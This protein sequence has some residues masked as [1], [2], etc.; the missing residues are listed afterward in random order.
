VAAEPDDQRD[1]GAN[2]L[3]FD[4]KNPDV[5]TRRLHQRRRAVG[6]LI[7]G[8]PEGGIYKTT[9]AGRSWTKLTRP[10]RG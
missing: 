3:A 7:G 1:T 4:P 9:N 2:D 6:Q 5:R 10:P 8:G